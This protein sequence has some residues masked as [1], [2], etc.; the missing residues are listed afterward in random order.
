M[1]GLLNINESIKLNEASGA[2]LLSHI[3]AGESRSA[4]SGTTVPPPD[5]DI[6]DGVYR[7]VQQRWCSGSAAEDVDASI[8]FISPTAPTGDLPVTM[9][10]PSAVGDANLVSKL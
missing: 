10:P 1:P 4:A 9:M 8:P 5:P 2:K 7:L 3:S 6:K